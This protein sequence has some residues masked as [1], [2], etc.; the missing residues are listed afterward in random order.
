MIMESSLIFTA[1]A[2]GY[3]GNGPQT[4]PARFGQGRMLA[5]PADVPG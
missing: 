2:G 4:H 1:A 5:L 3:A